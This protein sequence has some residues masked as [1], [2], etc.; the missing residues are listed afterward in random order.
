M[1][2]YVLKQTLQDIGKRI[3]EYI[4]KYYPLN[5]YLKQTLK[6]KYLWCSSPNEFNDPYDTM[7]NNNS[8]IAYEQLTGES[9]KYVLESTLNLLNK[10]AEKQRISC[11]SDIDNINAR[12]ILLWSHYSDGHKGLCVKFNLKILLNY[13]LNNYPETIIIPVVYKNKYPQIKIKYLGYDKVK[14]DLDFLRIKYVDW[15]YEQEYRVFHS[16]NKLPFPEDAVQ[17]IRFGCLC[18]DEDIKEIMQTCSYIDK[19]KKAQKSLTS[20]KLK[21]I[22]I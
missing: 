17:E 18:S 9:E 13:W 4:Y 1:K 3:P 6:E 11:F 5:S 2:N 21:Y 22:D 12:E 20:F 19:F 8:H 15:E 14:F 7:Y 10:F 16:E